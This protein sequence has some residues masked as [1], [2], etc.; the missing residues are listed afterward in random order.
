MYIVRVYWSGKIHNMCYIFTTFSLFVLLSVSNTNWITFFTG[1]I[2]CTNSVCDYVEG[3]T[4]HRQLCSKCI[5]VC[6]FQLMKKLL[7]THLGHS[8]IHTMCI[9]LQTRY[10]TVTLFFLFFF[11]LTSC[12]IVITICVYKWPEAFILLILPLNF[13]TCV[14][15]FEIPLDIIPQL[16]FKPP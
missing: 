13:E 3:N 1:I 6:V 15:L 7:G 16:S 5:V 2:V 9:M 4:V 11:S 10:V 12:I 8:R 14:T